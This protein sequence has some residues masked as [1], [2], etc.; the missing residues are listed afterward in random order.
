[1]R[2]EELKIG[3]WVHATIGAEPEANLRPIQ[4]IS[5]GQIDYAGWYFP[6]PL[7]EEIL[8]KAGFEKEEQ[9]APAL[10]IWNEWKHPLIQIE[11]AGTAGGT[12]NEFTYNGW[13][14]T[15]LK[16]VHQLQNLIFALRGAELNI[17]L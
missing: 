11:S 15:E 2:P 4:I 8:I 12:E 9:S 16:Y 7:T 3:N 13:N 6:I 10:A 5:G 14:G 1:M 17:E